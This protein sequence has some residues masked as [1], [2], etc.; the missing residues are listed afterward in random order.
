MRIIHTLTTCLLLLAGWSLQAQISDGFDYP[1]SAS[2]AGNGVSGNGWASGWEAVTDMDT[3]RI[4]DGGIL[5]EALLARTTN[6]RAVVTSTTEQNRYQRLL[7]TPFT[8][9]SGEFWFSVQMAIDGDPTGNV[10]TIS[11]IDTTDNTEAVTFGKRFGN[12]NLFATGAGSG[13]TNT[14]LLFQETAARWVVGHMVFDAGAGD[15]KLDMW[16]DPATGATP[17]EA[18]AQIMNKAYPDRPYHAVRIKA[19]GAAG[20][21]LSVDDIYLGASFAE[22]VPADLVTVGATP[23]GAVEKFN[24]EI[25]DSLK[26]VTSAGTGFDGDWTVVGGLSPIIAAGG[27]ESTTL[28][29]RTS[30]NRMA[31]TNN[32]RTVRRLAGDYGDVGRTFWVS[33][34]FQTENA[35]ANVSHFVLADADALG[36]SGGGGRLAQIGSGFNNAN[37][38][39][40]QGGPA[41]GTGVSSAEGHWVVLEIATNGTAA[42]DDIY[43]YLDPDPETQPSRDDAN[44]RGTRNLADWNAI[45]LLQEGGGDVTANWD[46]VY[47]GNAYAEVVPD[48]LEDTSVSQTAIAFDQFN[49]A[50]G[51]GLFGLGEMENGW[52]GAWDTIASDSFRGNVVVGGLANDNLLVKTSTNSFEG[53]SI[54]ENNRFIRY[55]EAPLTPESNPEIWFSTHMAVSGNVGNNV[56]TIVFADTTQD[57]YERIIIGKRFGNRNLFATG[58]GATNSGQFFEGT[59]ARWVVGRLMASDTAEQ[60]IMHL[61]VDPDPATMPELADADIADK[62]YPTANFNALS[63]KMEGAAGLNFNVDDVFLGSTFIDV[64][65]LDLEPIAPAPTGAIE[66][67]DYAA[68][69]GLD[70]Q[71]GGSGWNSPW[72]LTADNDAVITEGGVENFDILKQTSGNKVTFSQNGSVVRKLAGEYGDNGRSFWVGYW[73]QSAN[74][75]P[76]VTNLVLADSTNYAAGAAGELLQIGRSFNGSVLRIIGQGQTTVPA[77]EGHFV[78]LEL[79]TNGTAA[80][81]DVYMWVDPALNVTPSRDSAA[82]T[83]NANL[84]NWD[85]IGLKVAGNP[86]V[87]AEWDDIY[88]GRQ[89]ADVVPNDL[90]DILNPT[91]PV[92]AYE[93]FDYPAGEDLTDQNG[94]SG[95]LSGW[96]QVQGS[97]TVAAGSIESNRVE[98]VGNKASVVQSMNAVR[99]TRPYFARFAE[100]TPEKTTVWMTFLLDVT[101][102]SIGNSGS[103][104]LMDGDTSVLAIGATTGLGNFAVTYNGLPAVTSTTQTANGTNWV[105]VQMDLYGNGITD[106]ARIWV[107]PEADVLPNP[108]NA[109]FT[110]TDLEINNGFDKLS[111]QAGGAQTLSMFADEVYTGFSFRDVSPNFGS[112]DPDLLAYEPFNYGADQSLFGRG[113]VNAF[114]D[115]EWEDAGLIGEVNE[116]TITEG[117]IEGMD[118]ET[119]GNKAQFS[120][121]EPSTTMRADRKLAFPLLSDGRTYWMTFLMNTTEAAAL[122]NVSNVTFRSSGIGANGGQ[123][124]SVG[125]QFGNGLLGFVTPPSGNSRSSEVMDEGMHWLV[126]RVITV[127]GPEPDSVAMWIDPPVDVEPDTSTAFNYGLTTVFEGAPIDIMRIRVEGSGANQTPYVTNFDELRIATAWP[128]ARLTTGV[129]AP[130]EDDVFLLSAFPNPFGNELNVSFNATQSGRYDLQLFDIQGKQVANIFSGEVPVGEKQVQWNNDGLA[131]GFYFLRVVHGNRST[132]R[133]LILYR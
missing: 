59:S 14:G 107:N 65:P 11:F 27:I 15:W 124:L 48:D 1:T 83:G 2:L 51:T 53:V 100:D 29:R 35:G 31:V 16:V 61:W 28:L 52:A 96:E 32:T 93:P 21:D 118:L 49:Y 115:G 57:N 19:E 40:V 62:I 119:I 3:S 82:V 91:E 90:L 68:G 116:L 4:V 79:V 71:N 17:L 5:N 114:W 39:I 36:A 106:T 10:G 102:N 54:G 45:A 125:R 105:V 25:A 22:V 123:R 111:I 113:G 30:G 55:L 98:A 20:I 81:D 47:V 108:S 97:A 133:K 128:S 64:A 24:Y 89:F 103:V 117:S 7:A 121:L 130:D 50:G 88:V 94:G 131:N 66:T 42:N 38:A 86:G 126:F 122:D 112:D 9:A 46:D 72:L 44:A 73:F 99:Y 18:D 56:G 110:L 8:D 33:Y 84:T 78:V 6:N 80:N 69:A 12:R 127:D 77:D 23:D 41:S 132:V 85:A 26:D 95:F 129:I 104:G 67:M 120:Y 92:A 13:P 58:A 34:W 101:D 70:G 109:L 87:T 76:N 75:G 37:I 43:V 60:W 63:I 74:G